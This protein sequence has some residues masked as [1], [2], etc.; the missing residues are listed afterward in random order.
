MKVKNLN[1]YGKCDKRKRE[2][3]KEKRTMPF[4]LFTLPH[5]CCNQTTNKMLKVY[6]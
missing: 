6:K 5:L 4:S 2:K 1:E 3:V